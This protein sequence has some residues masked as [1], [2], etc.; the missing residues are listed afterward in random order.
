MAIGAFTRWLAALAAACVLLLAHHPARA[1]A[2][3]VGQPV[4][5][6]VRPAAPGTTP[7]AIL[8]RPAGFDCTTDQR[9]FGPGDYWVVSEPLNIGANAPARIRIASLWQESATLYARYADGGTIRLAGDGRATSRRLQ[10]GA[11]VE[12]ELP[13]RGVAA[14]RLLW[15]IDGS[16]NMRGVL[17]G[18]HAAT[19]AQSARSNIVLAALYAGFGGL[20]ASLL[21]YNV[22]LYGALRHRFQLAYCVMVAALMV[23]ALSSSGALAWAWPGIA[24]NDRLRVNYLALALS[25][26]SALAFARFFF[27]PRVFAGWVG[28]AVWAACAAVLGTAVAFVLCAPWQAKLLDQVGACSFILLLLTVIPILWR[29]W[30]LRSNYLWLFAFAWAGPIGLATVR[31]ANNFGLIGYSFLVDNSTLM[32]MAI[33]ALTSSLAIAYR[34][35]VLSVERDEAREHEI[36][37]RLLAD[38][39]PL[40]GLL[41]RRAF[42]SRAIGRE[43]DQTLLVLDID[44]FKQV[45]ETIGHDGGDEVLRVVARALR[46]AMPAGALVARIGGEE[47][48]CLCDAAEAMPASAVLDRL[49][50][51]RMPFDV[52]VTSSIGVCTGPLVR[53]VDWKMLYRQADRALFAAKAAGRDRARD[54]AQLAA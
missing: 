53:E 35:R 30:R 37:A 25:G 5:V 51:E 24:N 16:A 14:T 7:S 29:A 41:N 6:C 19:P 52:V 11:I 27:E 4:A 3:V 39:D 38:T 49:R 33:E 45:N 18:A 42:L 28:R 32:A 13:V 44:H 2:G 31:I 12:Y 40:T 21:L 9:R 46:Q 54:A 8:D 17:V 47:F 36:A 34:I 50:G 20:C 26:T 10:L 48:V 15:R 23:Y 43:G 1:Q 22:A